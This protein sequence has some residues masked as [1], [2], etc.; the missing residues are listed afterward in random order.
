[1][2]ETLKTLEILENLETLETLKTLKNLEGVGLYYQRCVHRG[3]I[4][5]L[6]LW[7]QSL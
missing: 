2:L 3:E 5:V 1:M 7:F 6:N 4:V